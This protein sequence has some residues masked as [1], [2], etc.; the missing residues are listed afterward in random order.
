MLIAL[1][2]VLGAPAAARAEGPEQRFIDAAR[3]G[4]LRAGDVGA[5]ELAGPAC[6]VGSKKSGAL[7]CVGHARA[8]D[9]SERWEIL[10]VDATGV[11][12]SAQVLGLSAAAAAAGD[13]PRA[14]AGG[15]AKANGALRAVRWSDELRWSHTYTLHG[16]KLD[17]G[18]TS[19]LTL[20]DGRTATIT[21]AGLEASDGT[22]L[23]VAPTAGFPR[24]RVTVYAVPGS[25]RLVAVVNDDDANGGGAVCTTR[26]IVS[27]SAP[28]AKPAAAGSASSLEGQ[29]ER[30]EQRVAA[31]GPMAEPITSAGASIPRKRLRFGAMGGLFGSVLGVLSYPPRFSKDKAAVL[32]RSRTVA[33]WKI[34]LRDQ[35]DTKEGAIELNAFMAQA[36]G[37]TSLTFRVL[38]QTYSGRAPTDEEA[39]D[40]MEA[41]LSVGASI[42]LPDAAFEGDED[43]NGMMALFMSRFN[44][45]YAGPAIKRM[46]KKKGDLRLG[47]Y[48]AIK[49]YAEDAADMQDEGVPGARVNPVDALMAA[50]LGSAFGG[51]ATLAEVPRLPTRDPKTREKRKQAFL[52]V[53]NGAKI[54][55][56]SL[57]QTQEDRDTQISELMVAVKVATAAASTF[58]SVDDQVVIKR[59][60]PV[61][62]A[63][64]KD[65]LAGNAEEAVRRLEHEF[66]EKAG[67]VADPVDMPEIEQ[68][69]LKLTF[70]A[71]LHY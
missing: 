71:G 20:P 31:G 66:G 25:S 27:G 8:A 7:L 30:V 11:A 13:E 2:G 19:S 58:T 63:F 37:A 68:G 6:F 21:E 5:L 67:T 45:K 39:T 9:R 69:V 44:A 34:F 36:V 28:A 64:L 59:L 14:D 50:A 22:R 49:A 33:E 61:A 65:C 42:D 18:G 56:A 40:L 62:E 35:A 52:L 60:L 3:S 70:E 47:D 38:G 24:T 15:L 4:Q 48:T 54:I 23:E 46:T 53:A 51:V 55:N 16:G 12:F 1:L 17:G 26:V 32:V 41:F 29:V 57:E 10:I 43:A